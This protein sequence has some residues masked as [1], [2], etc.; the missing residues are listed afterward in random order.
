MAVTIDLRDS[1]IHPSNKVDVGK[2]LAIWALAKSYGKPVPFSG[3]LF[4]SADIEGGHIRVSFEHVGDG[5][6]VARKEGIDAPVASKDRALAH[7]ELA[8][9]AGQWHPAEAT[10][11]GS[12][13]IVKSDSA[14]K[15]IAVRYACAGAP[16]DANLYN[17]AGLP[18]SPFCSK[19]ELLPWA[20]EK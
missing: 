7:F 9:E 10:I 4:K 18:A 11:D 19:L 20:E 14:A 13:V 15:P 2:R 1:D 12:T 5:L 3:P 16:T 6:M 17:R 8:D